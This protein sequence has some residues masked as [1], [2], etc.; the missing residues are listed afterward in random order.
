M[1]RAAHHIVP[2]EYLDE[3]KNR[4]QWRSSDKRAKLSGIP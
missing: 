4:K 1:E 2:V 3:Q